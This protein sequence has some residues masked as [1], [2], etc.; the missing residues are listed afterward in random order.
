MIETF[1]D[2][3]VENV[4]LNVDRGT[5]DIKVNGLTR[6]SSLRKEDGEWKLDT[7]GVAG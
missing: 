4:Q 1:K 5:A 3:D 2:A 6:K 7:T